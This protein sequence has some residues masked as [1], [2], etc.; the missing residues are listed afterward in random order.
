MAK[1]ENV[2]IVPMTRK[3]KILN[4]LKVAGI[5]VG[6]VLG[7]VAA[8]I[9]YVWLSGG[10]NPPYV[11][12]TEMHFSKNEYVI[13][14]LDNIALVPNEGCTELKDITLT[15]QDTNI[16]ALVE[17]DYTTAIKDNDEAEGEPAPQQ[18]PEATIANKYYVTIGQNIQVKPVTKKI[19]VGTDN[20]KEI[21]VGGWV[22]LIAEKELIQTE[23]WIFVDVPV[24]SLDLKL[25]TNLEKVE[26]QEGEEQ[27][28]DTYVVYPSSTISL[29]VTNNQ[30]SKSLDLPSTT[31]S[32]HPSGKTSTEFL[33]K[34]EVY[35]VVSDETLAS[36]DNDTG[37]VTVKPNVE[38]K[39]TVYAYIVSKY[40]DLGNE[41][42]LEDYILN[43]GEQEGFINWEQDFDTIR[44]KTKKIQ[45]NIKEITVET[46]T[47]AKDRLTF[48]L[49]SNNNKV[50][51]NY[52][53]TNSNVIDSEH[54]NIYHYAVDISLSY[55][56]SSKD[57]LFENIQLFAGYIDNT[58]TDG[59]FINNNYVVLDDKYIKISQPTI[60]HNSS[61][62]QLSWN[63][64]INEYKAYGNVLVFGYPVFNDQDEIVDYIYDYAEINISKVA[65]DGLTFKNVEKEIDIPWT[66]NQ[67]ETTTIDLNNTV[68]VS[69]TNATYN[70]YVQYFAPADNQILEVDNTIKIKT[71]DGK[72]YFAI[73]KTDNEGNKTYNIINPLSFGEK[74]SVVAVVLIY[75]TNG[76]L[77]EQDGYYQFDYIGNLSDSISISVV[78]NL[79]VE[80]VDVLD[81]SGVSINK[82]NN[83]TVA[84][85]DTFV[86]EITCDEAV[87][88]DTVFTWA[89]EGDANQ[90]IISQTNS[91]Q[92]LGNKLTYTLTANRAGT[93]TLFIADKNGNKITYIQ[94]ITVDILNTEL[95]ALTLETNAL[96]GVSVKLTPFDYQWKV[97]DKDGYLTSNDLM[98]TVTYEPENTNNKTVVLEAYQYLKDY[99]PEELNNL[100]PED[101]IGYKSD[102]LTFEQDYADG[103][104][105][106]PIINK[107]GKVIVFAK[108]LSGDIVSNPIIV[109][110]SI[111]E[112]V[113]EFSYGNRQTLD[114]VDGLSKSLTTYDA[115]DELEGRQGDKYRV[116]VY[117]KTQDTSVDSKK[118][119]Y[120][121]Q[122][123]N[124]VV[125]AQPSKN[126]LA[127]YYEFI[128]ISGL[129][130]Y[131]FA[132]EYTV[133]DNGLLVSTSGIAINNIAKTLILC[134]VDSNINETIVLVTDFGFVSTAEQSFV[135]EL[136]ADYKV[137][138][139]SNEYFAPGVIDIFAD[140]SVEFT[141]ASGT[142]LHLPEGYDV[143]KL[144]AAYLNKF[145]SY[146]CDLTISVFGTY[147][148]AVIDEDGRVT[149]EIRLY[150][151]P[152]DN[153]QISVVISKIKPDGNNGFSEQLLFTI[154]PGVK[155]NFEA[156]GYDAN[157]NQVLVVDTTVNT[158]EN[159]DYEFV[160]GHNVTLVDTVNLSNSKLQYINLN[161]SNITIQQIKFA[162]G[163]ITLVGV[164]VLGDNK[165]AKYDLATEFDINKTYYTKDDNG[166]YI[167][168]AEAKE[169]ELS[170]Y[171]EATILAELNNG[172]ISLQ[173]D[174][175]KNDIADFQL[176]LQ[177]TA[178]VENNG[179][180]TNV[181]S[182]YIVK[183]ELPK[184]N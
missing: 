152:E 127:D 28:F 95:Q 39:F 51:V 13:S 40:N 47:V 24:D 75:D 49:L 56:S 154:K 44:V 170:S 12:L 93:A 146:V 179:V 38:G 113:V 172:I 89:I 8:T 25:N 175:L 27:E 123:E 98:F 157:G 63:V 71:I 2:V 32:S 45:F 140:G 171:Y 33:N 128:D 156:N 104:N 133:D 21:N 134:D 176:K 149:G 54:S 174:L 62:R 53:N 183:F 15:V 86:L 55:P 106:A 131:K 17:D 107:A 58:A 138:T 68:T 119:Y 29:G 147:C 48:N 178:K 97:L 64:L 102:V 120:Q 7:V 94:N 117:T 46:L 19:N 18:E 72:E 31:L 163:Y 139:V 141:N 50:Q 10:F 52:L 184:G 37:V 122:G 5:C 136:V 84:K 1:K 79:K 78:K 151:I 161:D 164:D 96:N 91:V 90:G 69:P 110:I 42:N 115:Q 145:E 36:I 112:V 4:F 168:V 181:I 16:L 142:I 99:T 143:S 20:E 73:C 70:K 126:Y 11:P 148:S 82:N 100:K 101:L 76:E 22:K 59:K 26:P 155:S 88:D 180:S 173:N 124:Y 80:N 103:T 153:M 83:V 167:L 116:G 182:Y 9:L 160:S 144:D 177:I 67:G 105:I 14:E 125:V 30:P 35:Y 109:D 6:A 85:G 74:T 61:P 65:V 129:V 43:Y 166:Q 159:G 165:I 158:K 137:I 114:A 23:C 81:A 162:S 135:Y 34:K 60:N 121:L 57:V 132:S 169:E 66:D 87:L 111:P 108:S 77:I 3:Q 41:P 150:R 130:S 92:P 118:I